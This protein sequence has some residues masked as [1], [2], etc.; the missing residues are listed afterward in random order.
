ML[1]FLYVCMLQ[2]S[3][4]K[5]VLL[6]GLPVEILQLQKHSTKEKLYSGLQ[7]FESSKYAQCARDLRCSVFCLSCITA[8]IWLDMILYHDICKIN[9]VSLFL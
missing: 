6:S 8:Q 2:G 5:S 3:T 7:S 9:N 4:E 1:C